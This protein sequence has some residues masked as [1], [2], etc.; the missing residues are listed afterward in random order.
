MYKKKIQITFQSD[1][2]YNHKN[3]SKW[4]PLVTFQCDNSI[5]LSSLIKLHLCV[6]L[7]CQQSNRALMK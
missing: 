6:L 5:L 1:F 3:P 4:P 7:F 2:S